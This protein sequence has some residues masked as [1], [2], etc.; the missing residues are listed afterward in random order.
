MRLRRLTLLSA[1]ALS[2]GLCTS[3]NAETPIAGAQAGQIVGQNISGIW[4]SYPDDTSDAEDAFIEFPVPGDGPRLKEPYATEWKEFRAKREA[5]LA[6]GTPLVDPSTLCLPEGM[7]G[8]MAAIFPLEIL[9]TPGQVT[10]LAELFTQTRRIYL[11]RPMPALEDL[12]PSFYGFSSGRWEGDTLI[13]TTKG[14]KEDVRFFDI[15]HSLKMVITERIRLTGPD[16]M[17]NVISIEDPETLLEPYVF[18]YE[19]KRDPDYE[20]TEYFC[21]RD[22][23]LLKVNTD[24][25]VQMKTGEDIP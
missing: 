16:V 15:P 21:E 6:A 18:T 10:V 7:P 2:I 24:G 20:M 14:V 1:T 3:V 19:Y 25:T 5:M 4:E 23:A 22:D 11:N 9:Q 8:I 17:E 13:V 12:N